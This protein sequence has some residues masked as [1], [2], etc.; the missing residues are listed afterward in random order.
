MSVDDVGTSI[1]AGKR[2]VRAAVFQIDGV[3]DEITP[4]LFQVLEALSL[5]HI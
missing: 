4:G 5:I 2:P 3:H 1:R